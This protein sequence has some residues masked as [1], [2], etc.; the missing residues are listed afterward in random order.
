MQQKSIKSKSEHTETATHGTKYLGVD[1]SSEHLDVYLYGK[2]KRFNNNH[3]GLKK[4]RLCP[5][6]WR[7]ATPTLSKNQ[8]F[9]LDHSSHQW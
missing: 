3:E 6:K 2:Y 9:Q 4:L 1:I 8:I 7:M 5:T